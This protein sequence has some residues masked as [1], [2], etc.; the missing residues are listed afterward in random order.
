M[1]DSEGRR[2][3]PSG[4]VTRN[5]HGRKARWV[6]FSLVDAVT[7]QPAGI[8]IL[9]HPANLRHPSAWHAVMDDKIPFGYFSPAPLF[10]E[11][12]DVPAGKSITL[13]YRILVHPG[14][15]DTGWLDDQWR[16]LGRQSNPTH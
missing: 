12:Y 1:T 7:G 9:D 6:D 16:D 14:A 11:P 10:S 8:A 4:H 13:R 3:T 2:D 15:T 5:I